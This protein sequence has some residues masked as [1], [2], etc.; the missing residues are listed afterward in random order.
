VKVVAEVQGDSGERVFT[1]AWIIASA[2]TLF[3]AGV[4]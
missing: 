4:Y 2:P 3:S 1:R